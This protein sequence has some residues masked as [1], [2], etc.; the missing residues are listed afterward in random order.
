MLK[1]SDEA[2]QFIDLEKGQQ[3]SKWS[4]K[5]IYDEVY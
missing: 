1:T 3:E 4:L 2:E 5:C